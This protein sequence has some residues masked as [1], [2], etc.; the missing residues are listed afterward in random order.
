MSIAAVAA[1][2]ERFLVDPATA[3]FGPYELLADD[4]EERPIEELLAGRCYHLRMIDVRE[5]RTVDVQVF[6]GIGDIGGLLWEQDIRALLRMSGSRHPALP[7]VLDGGYRSADDTATIGHDVAGMAFVATRGSDRTAAAAA[8]RRW[9][10]EHPREAL[11][12]FRSLADGLAV[13]RGLG[14]A[15]RN[16]CPRAIDVHADHS[17]RLARFELSALVDDI[18]RATLDSSVRADG[19]RGLFLGDT[20]GLRYAPPE[21]VAFA[22]AVDADND[23]IESDH[24]DVFSLAAVVWEWLLG[25]FPDD[26]LPGPVDGL[27]DAER[28]AHLHQEYLAFHRYLRDTVGRADSIPP[29]L[30]QILVRMLDRDPDRRPT[31]DDVVNLLSAGYDRILATWEDRTSD[32]AHMVVFMPTESAET[33]FRWGLISEHPATADGRD[34]L[35]AFIT[36]DL[37][38]AMMTY[39]PDGADPFVRG[40]DRGLKRAATQLLR[41][42][43]VLWFCDLYRP[44]DRDNNLLAPVETALIIKYAVQQSQPWVERRLRDL[45]WLGT[46]A[47][48]EVDLVADDIDH[49]AMVRKLRDRPHWGSLIESTAPVDDS[50]PHELQYRRAIDWLLDYQDVELRARQYPF[51]CMEGTE[52]GD[53]VVR[54]DA[55]RD[56]DVVVTS[57]LFVKFAATPALRPEFGDFFERLENDDGGMDVDVI[58]DRSGRPGSR[59]AVAEAQ[60]VRRDG[61]DRVVLRRKPGS[62]P[63]PEKGWLRSRDDRGT[64]V[65]LDRQRDAAYELFRFRTLTSQLRNPRTIRTFEHH[66]AD[67][68]ADLAGDGGDAVR[69]MLVCEPFAAIQGPPGTGKTRVA[70]TAIAA[71]L[72]RHPTARVLVSAQSNYALDNLAAGVLRAIGATDTNGRPTDE[73]HSHVSPI[74]LRVV[75]RAVGALDRVADD[76]EQWTRSPLADRQQSRLHRHVDG[77]L[78]D[79]ERRLSEGLRS[80]LK[81]WQELLAPGGESVLP[82]LSDRLHRGANLIFATCATSTPDLL[83]PNAAV[84]FDWVVVEEAAKA[85]P[86]ELAIPLVR[87]LRWTLIGD[88][89]QLPAH[90]RTDVERFLDSCIADPHEGIALVGEERDRYLAALDLFGSLFTEDRT[91]SRNPPPLKRMATQFRMRKPIGDLVSR[92]FYPL[93]PQPTGEGRPTDGL[94]AGGLETFWDPDPD[95]RIPPIRLRSPRELDGESLVWLDTAGIASCRDH[96][97]WYNAGEAAI[98]VQLLQRLQPFPRPQEDGYG[99]SPLAILSPYLEQ[100]RLLSG[101]SLAAPHLSTIHAFQGREADMVIVS[102]VR[103]TARGHVEGAP[104]AQA[105]LGHLTQQELINVMF[106]RARRQ[107]VIVGRFDHYASVGDQDGFWPK[108]CRA[109][110]MYGTVLS[111]R[112]LFGDLPPL[113][114]AP[115]EAVEERAAARASS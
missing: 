110:Q 31:A 26:V 51:V 96:T 25:E 64:A 95:R 89:F 38:G 82:E 70:A 43:E 73:G 46:R 99:D 103:D 7:E 80:V 41:G 74:P 72:D 54:F 81:D 2:V 68:G 105:S 97:R 20:S 57:P 107:L 62:A 115:R 101:N 6:L 29:D 22:L 12:R 48:P 60:V 58:E 98:V 49:R 75:S 114:V 8:E 87:G 11:R 21:R 85:W 24:S 111:A 15:H 56:Q 50:S 108:V 102:L 61:P 39:A 13:L 71:Y 35:A 17:L 9:L 78:H 66:W 67:A 53:V 23:L 106:S 47:V 100:K 65:A 63:V 45:D 34:E 14:L 1:L 55:D 88:H 28:A 77:V 86:T 3:E 69:E 93:E 19:L 30:A 83:F 109:V 33:I 90:R 18:F 27:L 94:P 5:E 42:Q 84:V 79:R 76:V 91:A 112:E 104:S 36:S 52:R 59:R 32:R 10:R 40:G 4:D 113:V 16:L 44:R 92:V 37:R